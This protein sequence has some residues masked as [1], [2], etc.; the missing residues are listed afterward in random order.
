ML[1]P[2]SRLVIYLLNFWI[3]CT[4]IFTSYKS[5]LIHIK[6]ITLYLLKLSIHHAPPPYLPKLFYYHGSIIRSTLSWV[7]QQL[8]NSSN[9]DLNVEKNYPLINLQYMQVPVIGKWSF[10]KIQKISRIKKISLYFLSKC[11][12]SKKSHFE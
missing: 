12:N 5:W 7:T 10:Q 2:F 4:N 8:Y 1:P 6:L 9:F 11:R 3:V